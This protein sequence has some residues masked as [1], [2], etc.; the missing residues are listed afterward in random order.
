MNCNLF[1]AKTITKT[2]SAENRLGG[3]KQKQG[4]H[5]SV[6]TRKLPVL[7]RSPGIGI[8]P[9]PLAIG[10]TVPPPVRIPWPRVALWRVVVD[11]YRV[12]VVVCVVV[13]VVQV[14]VV[15]CLVTA[16]ST[17]LL[18]SCTGFDSVCVCFGVFDLLVCGYSGSDTQTHK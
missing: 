1:N 3:T 13:V 8:M 5:L 10:T 16:T 6:L 12:I 9:I 18:L 2:A 11:D 17:Q 4:K 7:R 15:C 14:T